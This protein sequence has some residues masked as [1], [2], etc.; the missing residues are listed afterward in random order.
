MVRFCFLHRRFLLFRFHRASLRSV[1][2][3]CWL[4]RRLL[5][6]HYL[7]I[8]PTRFAGF[9]VLLGT[10]VAELGSA[11]PWWI[12]WGPRHL[13]AFCYSTCSLLGHSIVPPVARQARHLPWIPCL[14]SLL[15]SFSWRTFFWDSPPSDRGWQGWLCLPFHDLQGL[16]LF[17]PGWTLWCADAPPAVLGVGGGYGIHPLIEPGSQRMDPVHNPGANSRCWVPTT[18]RCVFDDVKS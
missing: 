14:S 11:G 4:R 1:R 15:L 7:R 12:L 16:W 2:Q 8:C 13:N 17:C 3:G 18:T 5:T 9:I 10:A 6:W